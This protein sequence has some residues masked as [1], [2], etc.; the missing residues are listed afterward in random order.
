VIFAT[1]SIGLGRAVA[2]RLYSFQRSERGSVVRPFLQTPNYAE[3]LGELSFSSFKELGFDTILLVEGGTDVKTFQQLLRLFHKEHQVVIL[4]L[5]GDQLAKGGMEYELAEIKRLSDNI[6]VIVDSERTA[7]NAPPS[8]PRQEF[9]ET[10]AKLGFRICITDRLA[11]ENYLTDNAI[12]AEKGEKYRALGHFEKLA[13][14][15]VAWGKHENWRIASR[16]VMADL[17]GT[18]VGRFLAAL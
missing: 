8:K 10:C 7:A 16:M 18:D 12:K 4:P 1:H 17:D 13:D 14:T 2:E 15:P 9:Q 11:V 3:F 6:A 5:G